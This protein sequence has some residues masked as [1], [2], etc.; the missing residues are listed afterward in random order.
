[1]QVEMHL[2][3]LLSH[4]YLSEQMEA[5]GHWQEQLEEFHICGLRHRA[6]DPEQTH[7]QVTGSQTWLIEHLTGSILHIG[8]HLH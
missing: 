5:E 6:A 4:F 7:L 1:M 3:V 2:Q 8:T